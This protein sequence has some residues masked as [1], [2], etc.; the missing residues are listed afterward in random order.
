MVVVLETFAKMLIKKKL[1]AAFSCAGSLHGTY[2][3][4]DDEVPPSLSLR[5]FQKTRLLN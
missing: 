1:I 3:S 5:G 4:V 2:N